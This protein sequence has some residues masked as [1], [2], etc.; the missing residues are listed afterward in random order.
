MTSGSAGFV[1]QTSSNFKVTYEGGWG[2][3]L[4]QTPIGKIKDQDEVGECES[5]IEEE[6]IVQQETPQQMQKKGSTVTQPPKRA[7]NP[8][9]SFMT[10]KK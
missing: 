4:S 8:T 1:Q 7:F 5:I 3:D 6:I 10:K 9:T 2:G